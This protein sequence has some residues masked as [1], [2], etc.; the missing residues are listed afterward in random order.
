MPLRPHPKV[1]QVL[2]KTHKLTIFLSLPN[3]T[4]VSTVKEQVLSA[5]SD[6]VFKGIRGVPNILDAD[7]FV[8][9]RE[10]MERGRATASYE[11][12]TD[13]Q[14]LRD[15]VGDWAVLFIQFKNE[16]GEIQPVEV[17]IPSLADDD[18]DVSGMTNAG[19]DLAMDIDETREESSVRKGKRKAVD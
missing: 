5:F 4:P 16:S 1:F 2:V 14:L 19:I 9:S 3:V 17:T 18:D 11:V 15:V 8:L 13:D 10:V 12:L 6:D 7:D